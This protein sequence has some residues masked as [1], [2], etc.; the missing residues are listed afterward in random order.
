MVREFDAAS[1]AAVLEA[2][3]RLKIGTRWDEKIVGNGWRLHA[4]IANGIFLEELPAKGKHRPKLRRATRQSPQFAIRALAGVPGSSGLRPDALVDEA[5]VSPSDSYEAVK[6]KID[7]AAEKVLDRLRKEADRDPTLRGR[8][9][10]VVDPVSK[11]RWSET[12]VHF[13]QVVPEGSAPIDAEGK[14]F[15]LRSEWTKFHVY[16]PGSDF[17]LADPSYT[18]YASSSATD[19]RKL[20]M[21]LTGNP[22][23][24]SGLV[25]RDLPRWFDSQKIKYKHLFSS[26]H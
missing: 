26:W 2:M 9:M 25:Y 21:I 22:D 4:E 10:Q 15:T 7:D 8:I 16:S 17:Q 11:I 18:G 6:A 14:D 23:A 12:Q 1:K 19:A 20:Y 5:G 13:L 3:D 24:L